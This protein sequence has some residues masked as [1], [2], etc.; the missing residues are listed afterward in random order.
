M[1]YD[2]GKSRGYIYNISSGQGLPPLRELFKIID[3]FGMTP[4]EFF[5]ENPR[6][7]IRQA[8]NGMSKLRDEDI[9]ALLAVIERLCLM[10]EKIDGVK[11]SG[12]EDEPEHGVVVIMGEGR[13]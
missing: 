2:L 3:Y 13:K 9:E 4:S 5:N 10:R 1:S 11:L 8:V 7:L 6:F 12:G